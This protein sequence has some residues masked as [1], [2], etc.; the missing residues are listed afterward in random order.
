MSQIQSVGGGGG[1]SG[2]VN[3]PGSSTVG[4]LAIWNNTTGTLLADLATGTNNTILYSSSGTPAWGTPPGSMILLSTQTASSSSTISF[5]SFVSASYSS[6]VI[7]I[8]NLLPATNNTIL[9]MLFSTNNGSTYLNSGYAWTQGY[10]TSGGLAGA[11]G[12]SSDTSFQIQDSLNNTI[13]SNFTFF[14][15][16]INDASN[17]PQYLSQGSLI[18]QSGTTFSSMRGGGGFTSAS[19][20]NAVR[21]QMSSGNITSGTFK[22]YGVV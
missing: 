14:L 10:N 19:Q 5:T 17:P 20:I 21:F 4:D 3:G 7:I 16:N 8:K 13:P 9:R 6:Y 12:N 18:D 2:D 22:L 1:G 15:T 11:N